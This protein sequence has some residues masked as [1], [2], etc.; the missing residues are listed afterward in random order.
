[1]RLVDSLPG[2]ILPALMFY[3]FFLVP[4]RRVRAA[5]SWVETPCVMVSSSVKADETDSGFYTLLVTYEYDF[6]GRVY[7]SN[8]YSFSVLTTAGSWGKRRVARRLSAGARTTCYVNPHDPRQ[9]VIHPRL[10][11]DMV[12]SAVLA[13]LFFAAFLFMLP[14]LRFRITG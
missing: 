10:T 2:I 4:F 11:S 3:F 13:L 6:A 9:A 12:V 1:M 14:P 8:R 5:R 7:L